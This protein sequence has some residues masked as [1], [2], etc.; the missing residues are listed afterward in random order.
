[1]IKLEVK[2]EVKEILINDKDSFKVII[3]DNMNEV[4]CTIKDNYMNVS[5]IV[6][7]GAEIEVKGAIV[8]QARE[9]EGI[10]LNNIFQVESLKK[11]E[12]GECK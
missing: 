7:I 3:N 9:K 2:G 1:M 11:I 6:T 5:G 4:C 8:G 10:L 12:K